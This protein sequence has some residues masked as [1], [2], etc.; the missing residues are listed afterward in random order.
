MQCA[1]QRRLPRSTPSQSFAGSSLLSRWT[2]IGLVSMHAWAATT[3][4]AKSRKPAMN[5]A[6][7]FTALR[8]R[9]MCPQTGGDRCGFTPQ[10]NNTTIDAQTGPYLLPV[11]LL[12]L[13]PPGLRFDGKRG[14]R[15]REQ[16][17]YADRLARLLAV[18]VAALVDASQGLV[19]FLQEL[20]LAVAGAQLQ[21]VLFLDRRLIG[22]I[23]LELVLAQVLR[24]EV[25]LFQQLLLRLEQALTEKS[26]LLGAHVLRRGRAQQLG[27]GQAVLLRRL[28]LGRLG[29]FRR[30]LFYCFSTKHCSNPLIKRSC[31]RFLPMKTMVLE[32]FSSFPQ[33]R[34]KSPPMSMCTPW[35]TT[36]CALPFMYRIPL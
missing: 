25:R 11:E 20:P 36:R 24:G 30:G 14:G 35:N 6:M 32:R 10:T 33:A 9:A 34:P 8:L 16:P 4:W 31:G 27:L 7:L 18:A 5:K 1:R 2:A 28:F 12:L 21:R 13:L 29:R 15:P 17:R 26:E 3:A 22:G 19:D 23:G